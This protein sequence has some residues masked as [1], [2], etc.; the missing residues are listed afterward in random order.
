MYPARYDQDFDRGDDDADDESDA[1]DLT[2]LGDTMSEKHLSD[3]IPLAKRKM[4]KCSLCLCT[5][6]DKRNC[7]TLRLSA[8]SPIASRSPPIASPKASRT[9]PQSP[10]HFPSPETV[11][12]PSPVAIVATPSKE[13]SC[14]MQ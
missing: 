5:G 4:R 10:A 8:L 6:H 7:P 12:A 3:E 14:A 11:T 9:A 2:A 13:Q 1:L